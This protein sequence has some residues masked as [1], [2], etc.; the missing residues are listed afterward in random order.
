M[1]PFPFLYLLLVALALLVVAFITQRLQVAPVIEP[2]RTDGPG[3]YVVDAGGGLEDPALLAL[4]AQR[5]LGPEGA[6][7]SRPPRGVVWV[8]RALPRVAFTLF[9]S[10]R[11]VPR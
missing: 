5:V 9:P 2:I 1:L 11:V 6:G 4:R 10:G 3:D 8:G 7:Q